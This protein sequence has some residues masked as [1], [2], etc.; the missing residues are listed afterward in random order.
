MTD[1][2]DRVG[3]PADEVDSA[4]SETE[5]SVDDG[6]L[7]DVLD[8]LTRIDPTDRWVEILAAAI[9]AFAT[10]ASAWSAYQATRWNGVQAVAFAEAG[11]ARV[12][13]VR[14]SDLADTELAMVD[15]P[16]FERRLR[17]L[18]RCRAADHQ[19]ERP[20]GR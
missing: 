13:S 2:A 5:E 7:R 8:A 17:G 15:R 16:R 9:L 10:V 19:E 14:A 18:G 11:A 6:S 1:E 20:E 4:L 3:R 12:E